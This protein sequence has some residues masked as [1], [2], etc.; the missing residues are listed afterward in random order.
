MPRKGAA[1]RKRAREGKPPVKPGKQSWVH[2]TKLGFFTAYKEDFIAAAEIKE[3]GAF[4]TRIAKLY[5][6]KYGYNTA[7]G[8]D[9]E[10]GQDTADDVDEDEDVDTLLPEVA[11]ARSAYYTKLRNK[12]AVWYH[13]QYGG[14]VRTKQVPKTFKQ[15]FDRAELEPSEPTR[16]RELHYYSTNFYAERIKPRFITRLAAATRAAA[17]RGE[18]PPAEVALRQQVMKEAWLAETPAFRAEISQTIDKL[19]AAALEMYKVALA[20]DT[21]STAE[22]YSIALN[23]AAFYLTPFAEVAQQQFGMNVSILLC[24]PVPDRGGRIKVRS[25][26]AGFSN[27]LVPRIWSDFDR[28]GFDAAQRSF[29][30]FA[31]HCFTEEEC[32][33]RALQAIPSASVSDSDVDVNAHGTPAH[34]PNP[35]PAAITASNTPT[36][37][38]TATPH[39]PILTPTPTPDAEPDTTQFQSFRNPSYGMDDLFPMWDMDMEDAGYTGPAVGAAL[40]WE[41]SLMSPAEC[42]EYMEKLG[43][44]TPEMLNLAN[45]RAEAQRR[46]ERASNEAAAAAARARDERGKAAAAATAD[47]HGE[48]APEGAGDEGDKAAAA[49]TTR[50]HGEAAPEGAGDERDKAAAAATAGN[51]VGARGEAAPEGAAAVEHTRPKPKPAWRG[52]QSGGVMALERPEASGEENEGQGNGEGGWKD[53]DKSGWPQEL[54]NAFRAFERGKTWGGQNGCHGDVLAPQGE[55]N[56]RL[57]EIPTFMQRRRKWEKGVTLTSGIGPASAQGSFADRWWA[58][59]MRAQPAARVK[60]NGKL[61]PADAILMEEWVKFSKMAGK[62]GLLL[63]MGGLLWWGEAAAAA[64][65]SKMLLGDWRVAVLDMACALR[66]AV[67]AKD[68]GLDLNAEAENEAVA[69]PTTRTKRKKPEGVEDEE[70]KENEWPK[71]V[72]GPIGK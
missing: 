14:N 19:H 9:L 44:M 31:H 20:N 25:V 34:S 50:A 41:M 56:L 67:A 72:N 5:L 21:P 35:I 63:Y 54:I 16:K 55:K 45:E 29:V 57:E 53:Y 17:E 6:K 2:G 38:A 46:A 10:E 28:G 24:G 15:L 47:A 65:D 48:A 51:E 49:A 68:N 4:Y 18:K 23:N 8:G 30:N 40:R 13:A 52:V 1:A 43:T 61:G 33:A 26:H 42:M 36:P 70:D 60:A 11:E 71:Y 69:E 27:G 12:I 32:H 37:T 59:W 7:W 58:W 39:T 62:N 3:T 22:E 66:V 64:T